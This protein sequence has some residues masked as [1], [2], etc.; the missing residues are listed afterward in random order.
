MKRGTDYSRLPRDQRIV[1][2]YDVRDDKR[3]R[4]LFK[5]LGSYGFSVQ[6]SLFKATVSKAD[7][8][9]M[10]R[11][12]SEII[13]RERDRIMFAILCPRCYDRVEFMGE[14]LP[15]DTDDGVIIV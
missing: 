14:Q 3:R 4:K 8:E 12:M 6:Y 7:I 15:D 10:R 5:L 11:E 1:V 2:A 13:D 9:R